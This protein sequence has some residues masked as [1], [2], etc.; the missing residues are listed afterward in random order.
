MMHI[1]QGLYNSVPQDQFNPW[2]TFDHFSSYVAWPEDRH[3]FF[4]EKEQQLQEKDLLE[5]QQ[6]RI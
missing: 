6:G 1:H 2:M 5:L 3:I 4:G